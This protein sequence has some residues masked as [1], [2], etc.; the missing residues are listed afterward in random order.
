MLAPD[1]PRSAPPI[2]QLDV[3]VALALLALVVLLLRLALPDGLAALE[4]A[5]SVLR[6]GLGCLGRPDWLC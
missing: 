5:D 4:S 3:A 1:T 6:R 2:S